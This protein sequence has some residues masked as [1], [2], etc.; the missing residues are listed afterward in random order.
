MLPEST[1]QWRSEL[2]VTFS[3]CGDI[4]TSRSPR[5]TK[6]ESCD[7]GHP[8]PTLGPRSRDA[9]R[10]HR[11]GGGVI[12]VPALLFLFDF[13][14]DHAQG[15]TL[16]LMVPLIGLPAAWRYY[17]SALKPP[18]S[19]VPAVFWEETSAQRWQTGYLPMRLNGPSASPCWRSQPRC[20]SLHG[21]AQCRMSKPRH[22]DA[23]LGN[24]MLTER[25]ASSDHYSPN[26]SAH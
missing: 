25:R 16:A 15:T 18:W 1:S 6:G 24:H 2:A 3:E 26:C 9:E 5:Q 11:I 12:I 8:V 22:R 17:K 4:A 14:P 7:G 19:S 13:S 10:T 23:P 20:C 21:R